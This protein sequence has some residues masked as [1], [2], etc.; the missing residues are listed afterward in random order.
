MRIQIRFDEDKYPALAEWCSRV[1]RGV[2]PAALHLLNKVVSGENFNRHLT[3]EDIAIIREM[4]TKET[5][6]IVEN[7][8]IS[9]SKNPF[10]VVPNTTI[11]GLE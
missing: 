4:L 6:Y 7:I 9:K 3:D 1:G 2:G 5:D 10:P 8:F 11:G